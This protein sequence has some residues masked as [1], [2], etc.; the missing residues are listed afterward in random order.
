MGRYCFERL[1][2]FEDHE[3]IRFTG[4]GVEIVRDAAI[5]ASNQRRNFLEECNLFGSTTGLD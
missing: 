3:L 2:P 1:P 4:H 5:F